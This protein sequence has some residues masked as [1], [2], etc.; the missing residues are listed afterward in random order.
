[1][2]TLRYRPTLRR[3]LSALVAASGL[4]FAQ[5]AGATL[6]SDYVAHLQVPLASAMSL[7]ATVHARVTCEKTGGV[8]ITGIQICDDPGWGSNHS[9]V[10]DVPGVPITLAAT[11]MD[12][13]YVELAGGA[14]RSTHVSLGRLSGTLGDTSGGT[15]HFTIP[16][17]P[18]LGDLPVT[19]LRL[20]ER[21]DMDWGLHAWGNPD[22]SLIDGHLGSYLLSLR[23]MTD[24]SVHADTRLFGSDARINVG[25]PLGDG[26]TRGIDAIL[27]ERGADPSGRL[28]FR[29]SGSARL[30]D[31]PFAG[32]ILGAGIRIGE[33]ISV[34][35]PFELMGTARTAL[36]KPTYDGTVTGFWV[37]DSSGE[38]VSPSNLTQVSSSMPGF[39]CGRATALVD[40]GDGSP[41][42]GTCAMGEFPPLNITSA[43][44]GNVINWRASDVISYNPGTCGMTREIYTTLRVAAGTPDETVFTSASTAYGPVLWTDDY[45]SGAIAIGAPQT[46]M[47]LT[48]VGDSRASTVVSDL[49]AFVDFGNGAVI[50]CTAQPEL[51]HVV[52]NGGWDFQV[53]GTHTWTEPAPYSASTY[54]DPTTGAFVCPVSVKT[55]IKHADGRVVVSS[56][57][58]DLP[59]ASACSDAGGPS[60]VFSA[61][62]VGCKG[63]VPFSD[64]ASLCGAGWAPCQVDAWT[65]NHNGIAPT[66]NYWTA[67][68]LG[69]T[70]WTESTCSAS[71]SF[72]PN[73]GCRDSPI[74]VCAGGVDA[75]GNEC[76]W[77]GCGFEGGPSD[78]FGGCYENSSAGALCCR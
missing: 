23:G 65:G 52:G 72:N 58:V 37:D 71:K 38:P 12:L 10:I 51:C 42:P 77:S 48:D 74:R 4:A 54:R 1:M 75:L 39:S 33:V 22:L 9:F 62:M 61:T 53:V 55:T 2:I 45:Y 20:G 3:S 46:D 6:T 59:C 13:D 47:M 40:W 7:T 56:N 64:A 76:N 32:E 8:N 70:G 31:I 28:G 18:G 11:T 67:D 50:D 27:E 49:S 16:G 14:E 26:G 5:R 19:N 78:Y 25:A 34:D 21:T 66:Y 44:A 57:Q 41:Q 24:T 69:Y 35:I 60:D 43:P 68:A 17:V 36:P 15:P 29:L 73:D 63:T 30:W